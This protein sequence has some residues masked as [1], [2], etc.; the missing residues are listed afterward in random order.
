[1]GT[2]SDETLWKALVD[3]NMDEF[4]GDN[5]QGL[6]TQC[7]SDSLSVGQTQLICLARAILRKYF[8]FQ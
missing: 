3:S 7:S 6:E 4:Y 8:N 1:M 5:S 2:F